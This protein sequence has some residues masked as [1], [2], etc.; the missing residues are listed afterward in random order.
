MLEIQQKDVN[1][2]TI[3]TGD[4]GKQIEIS[5]IDLIHTEIEEGRWIYAGK[6]F[7]IFA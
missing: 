4:S 3:T 5:L 6:N 1:I 2:I 7:D